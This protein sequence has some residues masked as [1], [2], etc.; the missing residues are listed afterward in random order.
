MPISGYTSRWGSFWHHPLRVTFPAY[1]LF[2]FLRRGYADCEI[3]A[4][5]A[6]Y[7]VDGDRVLDAEEQKKMFADL[8]EQK[9]FI[10][11]CWF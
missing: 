9:V 4:V 11:P 6:R 2:L 8:Q 5:F 7:D 3:E 10:V 1:L